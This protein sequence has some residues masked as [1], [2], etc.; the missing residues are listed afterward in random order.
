[1]TYFRLGLGLCGKGWGRGCDV[2]I[3]KMGL[4]LR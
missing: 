2:G 3:V 1:M 4:G